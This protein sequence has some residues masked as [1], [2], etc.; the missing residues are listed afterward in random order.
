M[1]EN[2]QMIIGYYQT[3]L[4]KYFPQEKLGVADRFLFNRA[5]IDVAYQFSSLNESGPIICE[6][7]RSVFGL[8]EKYGFKPR[9]PE[10]EEDS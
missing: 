2:L 1:D 7:L 3:N 10:P 6:S 9:K 5:I 8:M 4:D